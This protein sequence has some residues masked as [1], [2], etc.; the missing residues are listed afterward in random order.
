MRQVNK[1]GGKKKKKKEGER[2]REGGQ[3]EAA[4]VKIG[5]STA[6]LANLYRVIVNLITKGRSERER[7]GK[8]RGG[9]KGGCGG[10]A[11]RK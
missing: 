4:E 9:G 7:G 5:N 8:G 1:G 6:S 2:R 11:E 10:A 3:A